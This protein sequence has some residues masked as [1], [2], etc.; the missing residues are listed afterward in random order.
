MAG[1]IAQI[2]I[3]RPGSGNA[4]GLATA[5]RLAAAVAQVREAAPEVLLVRG[6]GERVF[7]SGGDL[8]EFSALRSVPEA[9]GMALRLRTVL[10]DLAALEC[11]VIAALN[12]HA[13]GGGAELALAADLRIAAED[14]TLAFN[15][16]ALAIM[17]AWGGAERLA[18]LVG[19]SRALRLM[20]TGERVTA[21]DACELGLVDLVVKRPEFAERCQELA[22]Q[23]AASGPGVARAIK[24]TVSGVRPNRHP[25]H[26]AGAVSRFAELWVA[27]AHWT[28]AEALRARLEAARRELGSAARADPARTP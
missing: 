2:T 6:A 28:A 8:T 14:V 26:A 27:D 21:S 24:A 23:V 12:G 25:R 15:Q 11:V 20:L 1:A 9:T 18:E 10:D 19:R 22:R 17:P 4:I 13:L 3:D 7:V 5:E 16:S